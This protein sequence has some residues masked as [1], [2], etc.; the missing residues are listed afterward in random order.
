[1]YIHVHIP[2]TWS[3]WCTL[4]SIEVTQV[5]MA[6]RNTL[7]TSLGVSP[8]ALTVPW[9]VKL[10]M[11]VLV[12]KRGDINIYHHICAR[13][14]LLEW[15][16]TYTQYVYQIMLLH[17][18]MN[19]T[20][21]ISVSNVPVSAFS[22]DSKSPNRVL[23]LRC[24]WAQAVVSRKGGAPIFRKSPWVTRLALDLHPMGPRWKTVTN[25]RSR[26]RLTFLGRPK[27]VSCG[28]LVVIGILGGGVDPMYAPGRKVGLA[29]KDM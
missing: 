26:F 14:F 1:M 10:E 15:I 8:D 25:W 16:G 2:K 11:S 20:N 18:Q 9:V 17:I 21:H 22:F 23:F 4:A 7:S 6:V 13:T 24:W 29:E 19:Y 28:C 3:L 5:E 12:G 27:N